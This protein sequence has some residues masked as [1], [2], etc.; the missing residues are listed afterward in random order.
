MKVNFFLT[1]ITV[2]Q[3]VVYCAMR[4]YGGGSCT[5]VRKIPFLSGVC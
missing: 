5:K 2:A 3:E 4:F 1:Q